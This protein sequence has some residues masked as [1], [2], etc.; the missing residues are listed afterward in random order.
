MAERNWFIR[1]MVDN[2]VNQ[3]NKKSAWSKT[4]PTEPGFWWWYY[5]L[6]DQIDVFEIKQLKSGKLFVVNMDDDFYND[7]RYW[8]Q[9][10]IKPNGQLPERK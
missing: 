7:G 1:D 8:W 5:P 10:P 4:P 9:G 2:M 6:T 3:P